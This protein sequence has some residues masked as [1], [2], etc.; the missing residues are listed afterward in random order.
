[1]GKYQIDPLETDVG[2]YFYQTNHKDNKD[3]KAF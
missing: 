2:Q 1:M 3:N